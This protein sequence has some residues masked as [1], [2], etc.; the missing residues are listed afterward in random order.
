MS[1]VEERVSYYVLVT[2]DINPKIIDV[3]TDLSNETDLGHLAL[4]S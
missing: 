2:I 1:F 4:T 3:L